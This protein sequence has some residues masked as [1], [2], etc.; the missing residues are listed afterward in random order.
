MCCFSPIK[1]SLVS[2]V[3]IFNTSLHDVAPVSPLKL[4]V[5]NMNFSSEELMC[6]ILNDEFFYVDNSLQM[7]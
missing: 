7:F 4:T 6:V 2:V 3:F 1:S 5:K